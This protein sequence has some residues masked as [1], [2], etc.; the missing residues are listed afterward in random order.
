MERLMESNTQVLNGLRFGF[1]LWVALGHFLQLF[2]GPNVL[3][4][5]GAHIL[6]AAGS[7]V[8]GFIFISGFLMAYHYILRDPKEP[9][10]AWS[11]QKTFILRRLTRLYPVYACAIVVAYVT[12]DQTTLL[13]SLVLANV[14]GT[15]P[16]VPIITETP[17]H[18]F[19]HLTFT[20]GFFEAHES[21]VL[22]PAWSLS[23]EMQFYVVFP[24]LFYWLSA[25]WQKRFFPFLCLS[26]ACAALFPKFFGFYDN[27]GFL[28]HFGQ[29]SLLPYKIALFLL[30]MVAATTF[31]K[32]LSPAW[33]IMAAMAILPVQ[34][35]LST[36]AILFTLA[37][38]FLESGESLLPH[39]VYQP[40]VQLKRG[41]SSRLASWGADISYSMYLFHQ[42]LFPWVVFWIL[43]IFQD[44][45]GLGIPMVLLCVVCSFGS[46]FL[47][48]T[49]L[50]KTIEAPCIKMGKKWLERKRNL[51]T[52]V[53]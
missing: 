6:S 34:L 16:I 33:L 12:L 29:P 36:W 37:L 40:L 15:A 48:S 9:M 44:T 2:G 26:V 52:V 11:T 35:K 43:S 27:P 1:A 7:A 13:K 42:I 50:Y 45:L 47:L 3:S 39:W 21:S 20:H 38:L 8:D 28:Y 4:F 10:G 17:A 5:P 18:L 14:L 25:N 22:D 46:L 32:K 24:F 49:L 19:S 23:L 31:L 41:L 30:G 53:V 51:E